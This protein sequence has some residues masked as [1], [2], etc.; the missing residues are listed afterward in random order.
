MQGGEGSG[1]TYTV[2]V[3]VESGAEILA[4][5]SCVDT[6]RAIRE[7]C[8]ELVRNGYYD[9]SDHRGGGFYHPPHRIVGVEV[10]PRKEKT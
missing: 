8:V 7:A 5:I 4:S 2:A 10:R 1:M 3:I 6:P 9:H